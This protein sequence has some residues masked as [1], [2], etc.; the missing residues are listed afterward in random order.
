MRSVAAVIGE[1]LCLG[2]LAGSLMLPAATIA[3]DA[4]QMS[5]SNR[6]LVAPEA[7]PTVLTIAPQPVKTDVPKRAKFGPARAS[8]AAREKADWVVDS[9]DNRDLPFAVVD[10]TDARVFV[11]D[12]GGRLRGAAAALVGLARGD[13]SV[14]GIGTR[15]M[16]L[17]RPEERTT[18]SGRFVATL[19]RDLRGKEVLWVD[20]D[21]A[22]SMH[23]VV[24]GTPKE[25]RAER[26]ASPTPLDNRISYG[27]INVPATFFENIV[28]PAFT[29]TRGIVYVLPETT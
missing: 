21:N 23:P 17:I 27:C 1:A 6:S 24:K 16:S 3:D 18:P 9:D 2:L 25:R 19:G 5:N 13:V 12:P 26:L 15:A 29:G 28:R 22:I 20:Y 14:P 4:V 10:K 8:S 7:A 11:F